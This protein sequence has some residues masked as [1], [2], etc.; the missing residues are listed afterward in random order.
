MAAPAP[1]AGGDAQP[2]GGHV[3]APAA[4]KAA[5]GRPG[6]AVPDVEVRFEDVSWSIPLTTQAVRAGLPNVLGDI[7]RSVLFVPTALARAVLNAG[8][9][10]PKPEMFRVLDGVSGVIRPGTMTL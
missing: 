4:V 9:P 6:P 3:S 10:R 1:P 7:A 5:A 2:G 8:K